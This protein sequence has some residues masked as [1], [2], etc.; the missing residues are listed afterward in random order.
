[1]RIRHHGVPGS[2]SQSVEPATKLMMIVQHNCH[3]MN[4]F[5]RGCPCAD[6]IDEQIGNGRLI[7]A[8]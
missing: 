3:T 6:G 4:D 5:T 1:M 8:P 2:H 7:D